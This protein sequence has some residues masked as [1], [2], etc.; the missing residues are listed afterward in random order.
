[1]GIG[2]EVVARLTAV[3]GVDTKELKAGLAEA[4]AETKR[5]GDRMGKALG[6]ASKVAAVGLVAVGAAA[7]EGVK[8]AIALQQKMATLSRAMKNVHVDA[9]DAADAQDYLEQQSNK[10]GFAIGDLA[11]SF[12]KSVT[13]LGSYKK[14]QKETAL[15][16]N[17]ARSTGES[18][19]W[20]ISRR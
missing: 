11:D 19:R 13:A 17:I 7:F 1:M 6:A 8:G 5:S 16:E 18:S 14:A 4:E 3:V 9:K 12:T 15:A 2:G 10:T 20:R